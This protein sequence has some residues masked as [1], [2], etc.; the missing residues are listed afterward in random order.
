MVV[1]ADAADIERYRAAREFVEL[2]SS[3]RVQRYKGEWALVVYEHNR[4]IFW[5]ELGMERTIQ[6]A[7]QFAGNDVRVILRYHLE[8]VLATLWSMAAGDNL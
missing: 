4:P 7:A 1:Q 3:W 8:N 6:Q 5:V 2:T